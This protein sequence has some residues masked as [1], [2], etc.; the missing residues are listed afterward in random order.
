MTNSDHLAYSAEKQTEKNS[1]EYSQRALPEMQ[2]EALNECERLIQHF[3]KEASE[4]KRR[5]KHLKFLSISLTFI[6]TLLSALAATNATKEWPQL[7]WI[8]P[9]IA[10]LA[11]LCTTLL[12]QTHSQKIWVHSRSVQQRLQVEKFLYLQDAGNYSQLNNEEKIRHFS[13]RIMGIWSEG[14]ET[15]GQTVSEQKK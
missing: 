12:G 6:V 4:H 3:R 11:T 14:H 9:A 1:S 15:W 2:K 8:V 13:E 5:F 10:G 7:D